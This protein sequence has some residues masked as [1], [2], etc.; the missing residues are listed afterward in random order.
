MHV[1]HMRVAAA[2]EDPNLL[3]SEDDIYHSYHDQDAIVVPRSCAHVLQGEEREKTVLWGRWQ[4]RNETFGLFRCL[5]VGT[6]SLVP[7]A[8]SF[9]LSGMKQV[10]TQTAWLCFS[11]KTS[12]EAA[13][14]N[15]LAHSCA[16]AHA[17]T[18][19]SDRGANAL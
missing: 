6:D 11:L 3:Y 16:N 18:N 19:C 4:L 12:A 5:S 2:G 14:L 13:W 15:I 10:C 7:S 17:H 9:A 1:T 8:P